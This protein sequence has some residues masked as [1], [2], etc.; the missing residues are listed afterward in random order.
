MTELCREADLYTVPATE[1]TG[2]EDKHR[3]MAEMLVAA[4]TCDYDPATYA[5]HTA[6]RL[7]DL[8]AAKAADPTAT[9]TPIRAIAPEPE[10][11]V[12]AMLEASLAAIHA[13]KGAA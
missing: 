12:L 11:D 3:A 8:L 9:V 2:I 5:D 13:Q 7:A 10:V 6:E 4:V 1:I